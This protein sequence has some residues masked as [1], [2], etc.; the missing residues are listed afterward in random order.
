MSSS[1]ALKA[2]A[3]AL[4]NELGVDEDEAFSVVSELLK[5]VYTDCGDVS[6]DM[7]YIKHSRGKRV[8]ENM[9]VAVG[10]ECIGDYIGCSLGVI[11]HMSDEG[12]LLASWHYTPIDHD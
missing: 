8:S 6:D 1:M 5:E 3:M 12:V 2:A 7:L 9:W 11:P 4:A 10:V